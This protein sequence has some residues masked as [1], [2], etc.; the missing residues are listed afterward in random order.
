MYYDQHLTWA[1][2]IDDL[3]KRC[4]QDLNLIKSLK[5]T[6]WGTDQETSITLYRTLIR[7]KLDY[8]CQVYSS[9]PKSYLKK[10][11]RVQRKALLMSTGALNATSTAEL[12]IMT[13]ELPL[14]LRRQELM[15]K[16]AAR[17]STHPK[18]HPTF[19]AINKC[20]IPFRKQL[21]QKLPSG[22]QVHQLKSMIPTNLFLA[23]HSIVYEHEP[24]N[25]V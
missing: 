2:H 9:A 13:G 7:S 23:E 11:H 4:N 6:Q 22:K 8:G 15:L 3:V 14:N 24:W 10:L 19:L 25:N 12:Q 1:Y 5:G 18:T 20:N 17:L 16:Y 21:K